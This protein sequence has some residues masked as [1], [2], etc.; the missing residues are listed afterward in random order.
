MRPMRLHVASLKA[1]AGA[2]SLHTIA[3][4]AA[5]ASNGLDL[6]PTRRDPLAESGLIASEPGTVLGLA[7]PR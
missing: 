4:P 7:S 5:A 3:I 2:V 1:A 6:D